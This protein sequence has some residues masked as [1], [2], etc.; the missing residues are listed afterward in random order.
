MQELRKFSTAPEA[1]PQTEDSFMLFRTLE[2]DASKHTEDQ[3]SRLYKV[4]KNH[5]D[6][7]FSQ[8]SLSAEWKKQV[9]TFAELSLIVRKPAIEIISYLKEADYKKAVNKYVLCMPLLT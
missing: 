4:P 8:F 6:T 2:V 7:L 1:A 3:L 9:K 5:Q